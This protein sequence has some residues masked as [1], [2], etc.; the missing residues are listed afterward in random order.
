MNTT[1]ETINRLAINKKNTQSIEQAAVLFNE[2]YNK[3]IEFH[4]VVNNMETLL[5]LCGDSNNN[6]SSLA[7]KTADT[8]ITDFISM[9]STMSYLLIKPLINSLDSNKRTWTKI[10]SLQYLERICD[11]CF[12]DTFA[13]CIAFITGRSSLHV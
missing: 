8:I 10:V 2:V 4:Y 1:F 5:L 12:A 6:V 13:G 9:P 3:D 11:K 7:K